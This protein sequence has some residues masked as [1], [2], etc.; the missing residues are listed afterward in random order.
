MRALRDRDV[1]RLV[2]RAYAGLLAIHHL[3]DTG[4]EDGIVGIEAIEEPS[5]LGG[6]RKLTEINYVGADPWIVV[7]LNEDRTRRHVVAVASDGSILGAIG[8]P[9]DRTERAYLLQ[10]PV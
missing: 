2:D 3:I 4:A 6:G 7:L 1:E 8:W 5:S 10:R 9:T